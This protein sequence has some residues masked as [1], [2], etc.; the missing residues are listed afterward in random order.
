VVG[1]TRGPVDV[2]GSRKLTLRLR[3]RLRPGPYEL[4][5]RARGLATQ[6]LRLDVR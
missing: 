2:S 1:I 4:V 6:R 3:S 5:V